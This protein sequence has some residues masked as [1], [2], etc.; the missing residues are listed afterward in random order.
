[1]RTQLSTGGQH[2]EDVASGE[3]NDDD[4]MHNIG[5]INTSNAQNIR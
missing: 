2:L 4:G 5:V 3:A 1:L